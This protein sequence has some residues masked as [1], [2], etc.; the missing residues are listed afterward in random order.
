MMQALALLRAQ[1]HVCW[2]HWPAAESI[3][4]MMVFEICSNGLI[5]QYSTVWLNG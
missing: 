2:Q 1:I 4:R 3:T 5:K